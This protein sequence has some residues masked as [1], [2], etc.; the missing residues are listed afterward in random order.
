MRSKAAALLSAAA[1]LLT[2]CGN[3]RQEDA[4][5]IR[6]MNFG[7]EDSRYTCLEEAVSRYNM[8]NPNHPLTLEVER[9]TIIRHFLS[10]PPRMALWI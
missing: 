1:I 9:Y 10:R 6:L 4:V 3:L 8:A 2:G 5:T 7:Y